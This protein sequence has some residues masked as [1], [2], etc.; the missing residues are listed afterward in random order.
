M[1]NSW[2]RVKEAEEFSSK[3]H[4]RTLTITKIFTDGSKTG[5]KVEAAAY[6]F[7]GDNLIQEIKYKLRGQ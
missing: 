6:I 4:R 7:Q 3:S 2:N 1:T 5:E